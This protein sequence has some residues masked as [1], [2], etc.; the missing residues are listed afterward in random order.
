MRRLE[1]FFPGVAPAQWRQ[2]EAMAALHREWNARLNL[3]SSKDEAALEWHHYA[4]C[5]AASHFFRPAPGARVIDIGTGGGFP[6][7]VLAVL[8]PR[9]EFVL[10]DS[11]GKK[12]AAVA[13]IISRLSLR[14]ATVRN[15]RVE[16]LPGAGFDFATG[17]AVASLDKF[18]PLARSLLRK[19]AAS[20]DGMENGVLY[21]Q[22]GPLADEEA[23]LG[24]APAK[25]L[26][27]EVLLQDARFQEKHLLHYP[28]SVLAR[29]P[30]LGGSPVQGRG[31][32]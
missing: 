5:L 3:V 17:R 12:I 13:D 26:D 21:W 31:R 2:L 1:P 18:L 22:G 16:T 9:A 19:G 20:E 6:G 8:F 24:F 11:I 30:R 14:N 32:R 4:P 23:R 10:S 25:V 29:L 7:L 27:M 15:V 28:L